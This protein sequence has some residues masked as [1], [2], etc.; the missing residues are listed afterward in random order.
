MSDSPSVVVVGVIAMFV[1]I[2]IWELP[3][4]KGPQYRPPKY[5]SLLYRD[6]QKVPLLIDVYSIISVGFC[7]KT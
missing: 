5:C 2:C 6:P 7:A 3:K 4:I 1:Y